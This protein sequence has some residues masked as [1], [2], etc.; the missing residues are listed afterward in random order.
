MYMYY[1]LGHRLM[2]LPISVD[3]KE[4]R[5]WKFDTYI[6]WKAWKLKF[7]VFIPNNIL[8]TKNK[9][10]FEQIKK[11]SR[12]KF[13]I[14]RFKL[15]F[16]IMNSSFIIWIHGLD[17]KHQVW[18]LNLFWLNMCSVR[19]YRLVW[20]WPKVLAISQFRYQFWA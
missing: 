1:L 12:N 10:H 11:I 8:T 20:L 13:R 5:I 2:E 3:R 9:I 18:I 17:S 19:I 14:C 6:I 16:Y 4:V 7:I 15:V